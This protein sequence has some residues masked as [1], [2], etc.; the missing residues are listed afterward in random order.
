MN[1]EQD[2]WTVQAMKTYGGSFVKKLAELVQLADSNNLELIKTTWHVY[3]SQYEDM[4][5]KLQS[6]QE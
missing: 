3:W 5:K 2:Y 4:G 6:H 1:N